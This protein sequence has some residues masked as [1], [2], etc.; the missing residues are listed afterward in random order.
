MGQ[1]TSC[2]GEERKSSPYISGTTA[3]S[4]KLQHSYQS[5]SDPAQKVAIKFSDGRKQDGLIGGKC[6]RSNLIRTRTT[7][8]D[9]EDEDLLDRKSGYILV[10]LKGDKVVHIDQDYLIGCEVS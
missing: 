7:E 2:L 1:K 9:H 3:N 5:I 6:G 10:D 8:S 4:H